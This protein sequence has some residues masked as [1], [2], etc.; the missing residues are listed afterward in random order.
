MVEPLAAY[1]QIRP[2]RTAPEVVVIPCTV[3]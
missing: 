1:K 2:T 3:C